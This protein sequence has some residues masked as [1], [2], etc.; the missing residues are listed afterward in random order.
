MVV[1]IVH[2]V[3]ESCAEVFPGA[4]GRTERRV[5]LAEVHDLHAGG[6]G[7]TGRAVQARAVGADAGHRV[8]PSSSAPFAWPARIHDPRPWTMLET[9][10]DDRLV[11]ARTLAVEPC[12]DAADGCG[13]VGGS[14]ACGP[15]CAGAPRR[16]TRMGGSCGPPRLGSHADACQLGASVQEFREG[17]EPGRGWAAGVAGH[18]ATAEIRSPAIA[19]PS[20]DQNRTLIGTPRVPTRS[21]R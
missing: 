4:V 14:V 6:T 11:T 8:G 7:G 20:R 18:R 19:R 17:W 12:E 9:K 1:L 15:V 5:V 10:L 2:V 16:C 21:S 13:R 3:D